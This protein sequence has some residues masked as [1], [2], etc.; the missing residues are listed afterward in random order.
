MT[1]EIEKRSLLTNEAEFERVKKW[2]DSNAIFVDSKNMVSYLFREP[3]F[4]RIRVFE[5]KD[6]FV[7]THKS[8]DYNDVAREETETQESLCNLNDLIL[9]LK[10]KGFDKCSRIKTE[11]LTYSFKGLKIEL[12]K[13]D[14]L[15]M[16]VE[17]EALT[18]DAS[19][20][21]EFER[22]VIDVLELLG[23]DE[24]NAD[25]YQKMM[26]NMYIKSLISVEEQKF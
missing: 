8:G 25:I 26:D 16:I 1:Y 19:K 24:L 14:F 15:G 6:F 22:V 13:I 4:L 20:I 23:L 12:N 2:L 17:V 10:T 9:D 21:D 18:N 5:G 3:Y 11:R 7:V